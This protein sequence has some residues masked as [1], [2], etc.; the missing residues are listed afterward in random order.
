[1]TRKAITILFTCLILMSA[2]IV[3]GAG[4]LLYEHGAA[5]M[6]MAGAFTGLAN[7]PSAIWHNPAGIA[8]LKGT[9]ILVGGT[10]IAPKG[11]VTMDNLSGAPVYDRKNQIFL[12]PNFYMTH[13]LSDRLTFGLGLFAPFGLGTSWPNE[14]G[15]FPLRYMATKSDMKTVMLNE[16]LAYKFTEHLSIGAGVSYIHSALVE[17]ITQRATIGENAYDL[18]T[19]L[20][21][22]GRAFGWNIGLL[23][24]TKVV[25]FGFNYRSK[26]DIKYS[27]DVSSLLTYIPAP[28]QPYVPTA[29]D[30]KLMFKFPGI[31]SFGLAIQVND[32]LIWTIDVH[33]YLFKRYDYYMVTI[34]YP[35]P[36]SDQQMEFDTNWK[37]NMCYR[38]GVEYTVNDR[39]KV[40]G[41]VLYD[42]TPQPQTE[43]N[44]SLP[45]AS[46]IAF[47]AGF[48]RKFGKLALEFAYQ[49]EHFM[50]RS[51]DHK[52]IFG[53]YDP[54]PAFG[55]Y[56]C[57]SHLLGINVS[58]NF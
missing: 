5:A 47:T 51:S 42:V 27:G 43:V 19:T 16:V 38:T 1:M 30:A 45:D 10:L 32:D 54:N 23:Y 57:M 20:D 58:Y 49:Y 6:A 36:Y 55:T 21:V 17:D 31:M 28:Y 9:Q 26:F 25:S 40:R 35:E 53:E 50:K 48:S 39:W 3:Q 11:S 18:P 29:G 2:P 4:F 52:F 13:Q 46:R 56:K 8:W 7:D 14:N 15:D 12:M 37:A 34:D 24:K 33:D 41:G 44:P 22:S